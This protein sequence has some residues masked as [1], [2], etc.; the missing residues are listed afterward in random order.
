M[1]RRLR[2]RGRIPA[3]GAD[4]NSASGIEPTKSNWAKRPEDTPLVG[5]PVTGGITFSFGGL[6]QTTDS[7]VLNTSDR[8]IPGLYAAGNAT[9]G[10]F[11]NNY[12]GG[13]GLTYALV[14]GRIAGKE[15][16]AEQ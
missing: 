2:G 5:Y 10:L 11:F 7:E 15:A 1:Q 3:G 6:A 9:G 14:Y 13:T 16:A 8:A 4:G 12:S